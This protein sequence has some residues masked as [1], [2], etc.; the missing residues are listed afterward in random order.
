[1]G[2]NFM[3]YFKVL[4][5]FFSIITLQISAFQNNDLQKA[6]Q[7]LEDNK[8][9]E[10]KAILEEIIDD[11]DKNHEAYFNLGK[12]YMRL[13]DPEEATEN[14]EEAVDLQDKN[15]DYHFWLGQAIAMDAQNSNVISQAMMASDILKEFERTIDLDPKHIPGLMGVIGFYTN[16]PGIMGGDIEKAE[17]HAKEL[18]KLDEMR[19]RTSLA[20][21]YFKQEKMDSAEIQISILEEKFKNDRSLGNIYNSLGYYYLGEDNVEKAIEAFEKQVKVNP[22]S[23]NSHDSLGDGYKAAGRRDDA[24]AQYKKALEINPDFSAS[25]DNLEELQDKMEEE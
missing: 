19:G 11:D 5:F 18:V 15:A 7:F 6:K 8:L 4:F 25:A 20:Q 23:A 10:A 13:K 3:R 12:T 9:E 21:I 14:F 16:A 24:I 2:A 22:E 17:R 1:M